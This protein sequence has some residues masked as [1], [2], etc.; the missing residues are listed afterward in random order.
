MPYYTLENTKIYI[1]AESECRRER[2]IG[3]C[4]YAQVR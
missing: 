2:G 3:E 1:T 4:A